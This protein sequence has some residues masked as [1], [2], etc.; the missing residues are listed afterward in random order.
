[1]FPAGQ[2]TGTRPAQAR[3]GI[4]DPGCTYSGSF[5]TIQV[6]LLKNQNYEFKKFQ[7]FQKL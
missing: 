5:V 7:I 1:M 6:A 4:M 3:A 2:K